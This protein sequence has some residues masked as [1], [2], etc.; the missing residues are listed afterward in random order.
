MGGGG[1]T[2][3]APSTPYLLH[4]RRQIPRTDTQIKAEVHHRLV[5]KN[6]TPLRWSE[7]FKIEIERRKG[8]QL[9][10]Q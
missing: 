7:G 10:T 4:E 2:H 3:L 6:T 8:R 9:L 5:E 1:T